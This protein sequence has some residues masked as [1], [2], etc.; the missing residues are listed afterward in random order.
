MYKNMLAVTNRHLCGDGAFDLREPLL[1]QIQKVA[2]LPV[3]GII[4]RE[5]DLPEE[6]YERLAEAVLEICRG[7]GRRCILH[8]YPS[9][10]KRLGAEY[11]HVP[12]QMLRKRPE[13]AKE[14]RE[15]GVSVHSVQE[16]AEAEWFGASYVIAGHIFAT[17][18]KR[19]VPPRGLEYLQEI[20]AGVKI[21]VYGIG[22]I[23]E[24]NLPQVLK[25]GAAGGCMMSGFMRM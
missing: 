23:T 14:F 7:E 18:C 12:L 15:V 20:C 16:A 25:T 9:V 13:L 6:K 2:A 10:A 11:L 3:A 5:K 4:L 19:G 8:S 17:D 22:G 1:K 24:E 21:P